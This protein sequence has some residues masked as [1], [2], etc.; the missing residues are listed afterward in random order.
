MIGVT[1][2]VAGLTAVVA[3]AASLATC[4][5]ASPGPLDLG[6]PQALPASRSSHVVEIVMENK[7]DADILGS[8]QAPYVNGLARRYG[9]ATASFAITHPSLPNYLALTSGSTHGIAGDCTDCHV[10][11]TNLVDQL[12]TARVSWNAYMED[13]P[14]PCFRGAQSRGY[15]KK[16]DPFVYYDDVV[17]SPARCRHVVGFR[18]LAADVRA[19]ALPTF[20]FISPNLCHDSHD[21][22]VSTGER[23]LARL[24]PSLLRELG[25]HGFVVLTW[26]EGSSD[27]GCC[28]GAH[29]GRI[30]TI[31]AGPDVR[32]GGRDRA[33]VDHYG[34][35]R[36]IENALGLP[37]LA[38]AANPTHGSLAQLFRRAPRVH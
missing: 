19:G 15:A 2:R 25:P 38:A 11:G 4:G 5:S 24:V 1:A 13:L 14:R 34:V 32:R 30:P 22:A 10:G 17:G 33:P 6:A 26:D 36:T 8:R 31:V 21:C 28:G 18:G 16:H 12:E 3:G 27:R 29:G 37:P 20:A 9:R 23:F 7:E 35:L